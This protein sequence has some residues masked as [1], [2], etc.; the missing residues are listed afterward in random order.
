MTRADRAQ[1]VLDSLGRVVKRP[2]PPAQ[3]VSEK[4]CRSCQ[5]Q[6][7][8]AR[9]VNSNWAVLERREPDGDIVVV[10][11]IAIL[12]GEIHNNS[13]RFE[14]HKCQRSSQ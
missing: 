9:G 14:F 13:P 10:N 1:A 2:S 3:G 7:V 6:I 8:I 12:R 11:T 4:L 5:R